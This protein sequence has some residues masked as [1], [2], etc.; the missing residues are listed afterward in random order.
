MTRLFLGLLILQSGTSDLA[1]LKKSVLDSKAESKA[2]EAAAATLAADRDGAHF[3]VGLASEQKLPKELE[4]AVSAAIFKNPDFG[5]RA[6]ASQYF[7]RPAAGGK[8]FPALADLVKLKGDATNGR[9]VFF[10]AAS[11]CSKCHLFE[12]EGGDVGPNL[13]EIRGKHDRAKILDAILNPS[14]EIAF[15][16]EGVLVLMQDGAVHSGI[17]LGDGDDV[18]LKEPTGE[19]RSLPAARIRARKKLQTSLMPD[20]AAVGL[21]PQDLADLASFLLATGN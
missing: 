7:K 19:Q 20:N 12:G 9:K 8:P 17:V 1:A 5:V 6:L 11:A 15:G 21:S 10:G 3:L 18:I 4:A 16:F 2:R 14:A 13:T